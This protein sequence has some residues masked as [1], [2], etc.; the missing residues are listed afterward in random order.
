MQS[1]IEDYAIIGDGETGGL[2][3]RDGS[4]DWLCLPRFDSGACFAALLGTEE[5]GR[6]QIRPQGKVVG[7]KRQYRGDTLVLET[8]FETETGTA[9]VIDFMSFQVGA[10]D[11]V[12]I[13]EGRKGTV[14]MHME[15]IMRLDFGTVTPWVRR[16][17]EGINAI[18]GPDAMLIRTN[19]KMRGENF[20]TLAD[21]EVR[22]GERKSFSLTWYPSHKLPPERADP[23]ELLGST[24]E[25]W[26]KWAEQCNYEGPWREAVVRSLITLKALI[27]QPTGGMIAALTMS[28]P[29]DLGG[30]RNWDYRFCWLRDATFTLY[31]LL[32]SGFTDEAVAWRNWLMRA[33]AGRPSRIQ[34]LYGVGGERWLPEFK[35]PWLSG[36]ANSTPVRVGN[37]AHAQLQ[38]DVFGELMDT[39]HLARKR[40]LPAEKH[41][42]NI[43]H[44]LVNHLETIW[45]EPDEG[46]WEIRAGR[47]N[48]TYSKVM[49]WVAFDRAVKAVE[50]FGLNGPVEKWRRLRAE[51]HADVCQKGFNAD[52]N[53][54]TQ[55]YG[56]RNLD[57]SLLVLPV[58]G[59]LPPE[60]P[61]IRGTVKA[62]Q[63]D[64]KCDGFVRRYDA[65]RKLDGLTG[66]EGA[67]LMCTFW[68]ADA[69]AMLGRREEAVALFERLL[70]LR[71]DVGLL[72][73]EYDP[74]QKC[75][76]GN[77]P[78]A[79]SHVALIN[80][81]RNLSAAGGPS[82]HRS[83]H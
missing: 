19:V 11:V 81:A 29:E 48:F 72:S 2:V 61:R 3:S 52:M 68:L 24:E 28:L 47:Q 56:S 59:F 32:D 9:A 80:T 73:E 30:E 34:P 13:V 67:F 65:G 69:L 12:R 36:Y 66:D 1:R 82:A 54:F 14:P 64:L 44:A 83:D 17:E 45:R 51:I 27:Y 18:A 74:A 39:L 40:G 79:F 25:W 23:L 8:E 53:S 20:R 63:R 16:T 62:I 60:D 55:S 77:F 50:Q 6:W 7:Q 26:T 78:Q 58:V 4:I 76:L 75:F 22:E 46:I 70:A 35:I 10:A 33:V 37:Q 41:I 38:L 57:A 71:N 43:Q 5:N 49:A 42:W 15:L 31:A 21:F